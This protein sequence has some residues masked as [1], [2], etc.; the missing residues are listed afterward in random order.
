MEREELHI[1]LEQKDIKQVN[2]CMYLGGNISENGRVRMEVRRKIQ[3]GANS[4]RNVE[5]VM[6]F[7]CGAS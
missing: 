7:L 1:R 5:G 4:W 2:T 3:A 6:L